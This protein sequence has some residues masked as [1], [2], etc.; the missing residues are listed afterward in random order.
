MS[1]EFLVACGQQSEEEDEEPHPVDTHSQIQQPDAISFII[2][3]GEDGEGEGYTEE[4]DGGSG[5]SGPTSVYGSNTQS[6]AS[7]PPGA[8]GLS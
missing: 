1:F 7:S 5:C 2:M 8:V 3:C 4:D 6:K